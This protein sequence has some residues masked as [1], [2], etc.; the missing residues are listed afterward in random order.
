[1]RQL[2]E[3]RNE[4]AHNV[5]NAMFSF[6][7]HVASRDANQLAKLV[8]SFGHGVNEIIAIGDLSISREKFVLENP[9]LALWI[10]SAEIIA[11]LHLEFEVAAFH[12][13]QIALA[14]YQR[15]VQDAN[16][17]NPKQGASET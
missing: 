11:C 2:G 3:L 15:L 6:T 13:N 1:M 17:L 16:A 14:E 7:K 9:K 10:T 5:R 12:V 4:L 8:K